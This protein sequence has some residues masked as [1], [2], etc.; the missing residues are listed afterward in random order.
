MKAALLRMYV[1][2][3]VPSFF[4]FSVLLIALMLVFPVYYI[5]KG[6]NYFDDIETLLGAFKE[7]IED[8]I[9]LAKTIN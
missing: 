5:F 9:D 2:L 4:L 7:H 3:L 1:V 6:R 8:M